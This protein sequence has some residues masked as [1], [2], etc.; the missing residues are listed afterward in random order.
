MGPAYKFKAMALCGWCGRQT[1][2]S[3]EYQN[4]KTVLRLCP[5]CAR[6][7]IGKLGAE[8]LHQSPPPD[9]DAIPGT[10]RWIIYTALVL[11]A[12]VLIPLVFVVMHFFRPGP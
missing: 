1:S 7:G 8:L 3:K 6:D 10:P 12:T 2:R 11:L 5:D 9:D 4:G